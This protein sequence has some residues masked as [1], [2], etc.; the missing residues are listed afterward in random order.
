MKSAQ[1]KHLQRFQ[2]QRVLP[3]QGR[4][5][6]RHQHTVQPSPCDG[7]VKSSRET[8]LLVVLGH[9]NTAEGGRANC[10]LYW[11]KAFNKGDGTIPSHRIGNED[12]GRVGE[13]KDNW[14]EEP[15]GNGFFCYAQPAKSSPVWQ[16]H[17]HEMFPGLRA[18]NPAHMEVFALYPAPKPVTSTQTQSSPHGAVTRTPKLQVQPLRRHSVP[19][20]RHFPGA[21]AVQQDQKAALPATPAQTTQYISREGRTNSLVAPACRYRRFGPSNF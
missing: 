13:E 6:F 10:C 1:P 4:H 21:L 5:V 18:G 12:E 3:Q 17:E 19:R 15:Q 16:R 2:H 9:A 8:T 7:E 14:A 11:E 20:H